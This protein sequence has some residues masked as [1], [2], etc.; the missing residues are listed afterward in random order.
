MLGTKTQGQTQKRQNPGR[1]RDADSESHNGKV[2]DRTETISY[3][4]RRHRE[5][6]K[7]M[8]TLVPSW[9][10]YS[11]RKFFDLSP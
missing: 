10:N 1:Y 2:I 5:K 11:K 8:K 6:S 9:L 3:T 4:E 7:R